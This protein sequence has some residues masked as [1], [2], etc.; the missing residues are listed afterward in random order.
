MSAVTNPTEIWVAQDM[1]T[2]RLWSETIGFSEREAASKMV[3]L[4]LGGLIGEGHLD[5]WDCLQIMAM[6]QQ[7]GR[8]KLVSLELSA[9]AVAA[10][11]TQPEGAAK[12]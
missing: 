12:P 10:L 11:S 7:N 9:E 4:F 1:R 8:Y 5:S 6:A 3:H 2:G